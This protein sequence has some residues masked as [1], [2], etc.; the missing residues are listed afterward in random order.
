MAAGSSVTVAGA[1]SSRAKSIKSGDLAPNLLHQAQGGVGKLIELEVSNLQR[2]PVD[3]GGIKRMPVSGS[4][5]TKEKSF[6]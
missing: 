5:K 6:T 4:K 2:S 3:R 1:L